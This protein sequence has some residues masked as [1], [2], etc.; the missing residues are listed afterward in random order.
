[1]HNTWSISAQNI[2]FHVARSPRRWPV[3]LRTER[4]M[5]LLGFG[6]ATGDDDMPALPLPCVGDFELPDDVLRHVELVD[7]ID[8]EIL[9]ALASFRRPIFRT[10]FPT[11]FPQFRQ[12]DHDRGIVLPKHS[13][14]IFHCL[15]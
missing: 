7:G 11:H 5:P 1:M 3:L 10:F 4:A 2:A 15:V 14:K 13:P 9:V 12:H 6:A 8:D